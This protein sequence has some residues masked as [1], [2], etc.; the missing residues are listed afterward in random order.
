MT[1]KRKTPA[2]RRAEGDELAAARLTGAMQ[3]L[4]DA[5]KSAQ[6]RGLDVQVNVDRWFS[7]NPSVVVRRSF[8]TGKSILVRLAEWDGVTLRL[9]EPGVW[10]PRSRRA[11]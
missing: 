11:P 2:E 8:K 4:V 10:V 6:E 9:K 5:W 3:E 1:K 7:S